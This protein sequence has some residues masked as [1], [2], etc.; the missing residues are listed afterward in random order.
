M[1]FTVLHAAG[2][3]GAACKGQMA[4]LKEDLKQ[5]TRVKQGGKGRCPRR[6]RSYTRRIQWGNTHT[7]G[8]LLS[9][10][11]RAI[12]SCP[13]NPR[14]SAQ[15]LTQYECSVNPKKMHGFVEGVTLRD[16]I[17]EPLSEA[18]RQKGQKSQNPLSTPNSCWLNALGAERMLYCLKGRG[19]SSVPNVSSTVNWFLSSG[20]MG[21]S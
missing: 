14:C 17:A 7:K 10:N 19:T 6:C 4:W 8:R 13:V 11:R 5:K 3:W 9:C 15:H 12:S 21:T 16:R 2:D 18:S 1:S 20:C